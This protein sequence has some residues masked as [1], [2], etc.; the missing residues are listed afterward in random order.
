MIEVEMFDKVGVCERVGWFPGKFVV[1][2]PLNKV[3]EFAMAGAGGYD[4]LN[5][6]LFFVVD[7]NGWRRR[8]SLSRKGV[9]EGRLE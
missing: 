8:V 4:F 5:K 2:C 6:L 1:S 7:D 3:L 9:R